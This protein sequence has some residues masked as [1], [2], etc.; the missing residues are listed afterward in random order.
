VWYNFNVACCKT[1]CSHMC[2]KAPLLKAFGNVIFLHGFRTPFLHFCVNKFTVKFVTLV[3]EWFWFLFNNVVLH[4]F[5]EKCVYSL[6]GVFCNSFAVLF[7][8]GFLPR[9]SIIQNRSPECV[10]YYL[11]EI[12]ARPK[13]GTPKFSPRFKII[14]VNP[15]NSSGLADNN[16]L[17][18]VDSLRKVR[19]WKTPY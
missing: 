17:G 2:S 12:L 15:N 11:K 8:T 6:F 14:L 10:Q 3:T 16:L 5:T 1:S 18:R 19:P 13:G 9:F 4:F 7:E